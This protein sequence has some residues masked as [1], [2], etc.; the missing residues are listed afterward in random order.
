MKKKIL[1]KAPVLTRSGY[2]EQS[3]F[4]LRALQDRE[5]LF[6]IYIQ[7]LQWGATSWIN[8]NSIDREWTDRIIEKTIAYVQQGGQFDMSFQ[9]TIPNEWERLAPINIGYTA[10]IETNKVAHPWI[11][12]GNLMDKIIVVSDHAKHCYENTVYEGV[13][14]TTQERMT[15]SLQTSIETVNYPA[16]S[17]ES[18]PDLGIELDYDTNFISIAQFGPRKNLPNTVKWFIEE[19][20]DDEVG[21]LLKSNIAKN[22]LMDRNKMQHDL[23]QFVNNFPDKKC[24]IYLL[25]GDMEDDEIHSLYVHPQIS[26]LVSLAHGEGF[27]LPIFESAY[28]GLPVVCTGWSGQLDFLVDEEGKEHFYNVSYDLQ[29]VQNEVVWEGVLIKESMWAFPREQSAKQKM[30]QCYEDIKNKDK[31]SHALKASDFADSVQERFAKDK[32]YEKMVGAI[33]H[34]IESTEEKE[35]RGILDQVVEYE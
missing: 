8:D 19:F 13:N 16:K 18:L 24:K 34:F 3:R 26:A 27:G 4:A 29:P 23:K 28:S 32:Q 6:D 11:E 17:F 22:C 20:H 14:S 5:D 12:K 35:W 30:R 9:V 21:L 1:F 7:P 10:G 33:A 25:H 15:L 31:N 2:G